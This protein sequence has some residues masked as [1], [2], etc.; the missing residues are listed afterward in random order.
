MAYH[1]MLESES[2]IWWE[3]LNLVYLFLHPL[4]S[5]D[6]VPQKP[7]S[8]GIIELQLVGKFIQFAYVVEDGPGDEQVPIQ[9]GVVVTDSVQESGNGDSVFEETTQIGMMH[10]LGSWGLF[11]PFDKVSVSEE[12]LQKTF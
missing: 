3:S 7:A 12:A 6:H 9:T 8:V 1:E 11:H 10:G 2:E 4:N 5:E